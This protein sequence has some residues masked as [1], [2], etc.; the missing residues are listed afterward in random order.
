MP[1]ILNESLQSAPE[2]FHQPMIRFLQKDNR[3]VKIIFIVIIAVAVVTMVITLVPGIFADEATNSDSYATVHS[4]GIFGRYFGTTTSIS[5]PEVQQ[6]AE[7]IM[8]Q[9]HYPDMVLPYLMPQAAQALIQREVLLQEANRLGLQ[10]GDA[11]LRRALQT[12]PFA[13]ALFPGGQF[14]GQDRY[15]DFV[16]NYFHTSI[17]DFETQVKKEIEINR[18][19]AM[20]TGAITV[21]DQEVRDAYKQQGTK[22]KFDYAVLNAE[23][24]RKEINPTDAELQAFFKQSAARYKDAIPETRRIAYIPLSPTDV[25]SGVPSVTDQQIQDYYQAH[26]KDFQ[27]PEE[28][29]VRH[30]LIKVAAGADAK[31]DAAAKEKAEALLKQ[32]KGGADF[33]ALAKANSDDPGSKESGGE[34]GMIQ[35]GVTVPPF[36]QAAFSLQ[37]G[38]ISDV[39]KTQFG[40][41]ILKVEEKQTAHLKPLDEVKAQILATLTRQQEAAQQAVYAQQ[42]A[43]EAGKTGLAQTAAAHHLQV[44]TTDYVPQSAVLNG[45]PD[46]SK[47]LTQAF[48]AKPGA[49][50]GVTGTGEG[51]AIFQ[52]VDAKPAH[53]PTF[54]EYKT[55]LLDDFREQQLPQLLAR[56]TN[57][58]AD[59]AHA[60]NNLAQ[61]AKEVGAIVKTSDLVAHTAQVPDIGELATAA[62]DLFDLNVGQ[63]SKPINTGHS[64]IV[65][66]IVEKQEPTTEETAKNFDTTKE[67]LLAEKR[68]QM[69]AVFVTSLT[70]RYEKQGGI[71]MNKAKATPSLGMQS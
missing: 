40:Y 6:V 58:L 46:G 55:H 15:A 67:Q 13:Q 38:Q 24:L 29:K 26:Q 53:A 34:L 71:R 62:P 30:I 65:A 2:G 22:I 4:G 45:L 32:I 7:R 42:L 52:V 27:V 61:A 9:K 64:G 17:Q 14:I 63:Y 12:G 69:F 41:H 50:P 70:D 11:D 54:E 47:L 16:S 56:K 57:E 3:V 39:V 43:A 49:A 28:V 21:S 35:R 36:E 25:P 5:T 68:E 31:T 66:K 10:V 44:V 37:P 20:V 60:E 33:A 19:E 1:R 51:F 59:K 18:L 23:D 48:A 8:Q